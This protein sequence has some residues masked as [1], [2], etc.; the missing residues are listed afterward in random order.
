MSRLAVVTARAPNDPTQALKGAIVA[1]KV[2]SRA[3]ITEP[4]AF[5]GLLRAINGFKG[6]PTTK[7]ALQLLASNGNL[8]K[9]PFVLDGKSGIVGFNEEEWMELFPGA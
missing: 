4:V 6:Q 7:A 2:K 1:P 9:R 3:A 8:V 5:G